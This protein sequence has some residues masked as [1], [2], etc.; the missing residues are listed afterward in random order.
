M[1]RVVDPVRF[2]TGAVGEPGAREFFIQ[3][4]TGLAGA[5]TAHCVGLEKEQASRLAVRLQEFVARYENATGIDIN[6]VAPRDQDPL[7]TPIEPDF[8]VGD[9]SITFD[10]DAKR[11]T[12][13]FFP[14]GIDPEDYSDDNPPA[15]GLSVAVDA[16][17]AREFVRRTL[18]VVAAGRPPCPLCHGPLGATGHICPRA[19]G[20]R[21]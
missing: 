16:P 7:H 14:L 10:S 6:P 18:S 21:R 1:K 12:V 5:G 3:V 17:A 15:V 9:M 11:F 20:Y 8:L 2:V 19:N 4:T 13:E